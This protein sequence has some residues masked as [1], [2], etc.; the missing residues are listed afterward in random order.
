MHLVEVYVVRAKSAQTCF[1]GVNEML[2]RQA[3]VVGTGPG[4]DESLC[5]DDEIVAMAAH[6][7][8]DYDF[9]VPGIVGVGGVDEVDARVECRVYD[10][11][12]AVIVHVARA[13]HIR[14]HAYG[15]HFQTAAAKPDVVHAV[16]LSCFCS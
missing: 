8:P 3:D 1:H 14:A 2:S 5:C 7:F 9:R 4:G 12:C 15:G 16:S 10:R 13:E 6:R 11:Y